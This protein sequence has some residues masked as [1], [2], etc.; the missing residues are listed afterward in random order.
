MTQ[1]NMT[2]LRKVL[3][4]GFGIGFIAFAATIGIEQAFGIDWH[5]PRGIHKDGHGHGG[6]H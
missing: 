5:D 2:L 3:F 1:S 4:R 6:H